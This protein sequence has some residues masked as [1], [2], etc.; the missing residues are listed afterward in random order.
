MD[1]ARYFEYYLQ[2]LE[3]DLKILQRIMNEPSLEMND[4]ELKEVMRIIHNIKSDAAMM[5]FQEFS[6]DAKG[7][8]DRIRNYLEHRASP[9]IDRMV[10]SQWMTSIE[11]YYIGIKKSGT[12]IAEQ[13]ID[14][15][16]SA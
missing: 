4:A 6:I 9:P 16:E 10:F 7:Y 2:K 12:K 15:N 5:H 13:N 11:R 3:K 1:M 8:E 14:E